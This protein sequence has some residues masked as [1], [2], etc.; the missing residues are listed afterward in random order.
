M[1]FSDKESEA[2]DGFFRRK[3]GKYEMHTNFIQ[4]A[5]KLYY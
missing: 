4:S 1:D 2:M 3:R 5:D